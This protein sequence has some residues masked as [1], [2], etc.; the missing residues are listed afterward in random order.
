MLTLTYIV[1][2]SIWP[3]PVGDAV[4]FADELLEF[5][6]AR[7]DQKGSVQL[8]NH[9]HSPERG[10]DLWCARVRCSSRFS[11]G[12]ILSQN[13]KNIGSALKDL[14]TMRSTLVHIQSL[15]SPCHRAARERGHSRLVGLN[16]KTSFG[17][18]SYLQMEQLEEV[19]YGDNF[20]SLEGT[21]PLPRIDRESERVTL[22]LGVS[23]SR[24]FKV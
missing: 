1:A 6:F 4:Q 18:R 15:L 13:L 3:S 5:A 23:L 19:G 14:E 2:R 22:R 21:L 17:A 20:T 9:A 7:N 10:P 11:E 24:F 16:S 8:V 12:G